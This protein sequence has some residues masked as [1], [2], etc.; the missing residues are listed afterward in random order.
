MIRKL[1]KNENVTQMLRYI[2]LYMN[3]NH[4][5]TFK[6][7]QYCKC[8]VN[9]KSSPFILTIEDETNLLNNHIQKFLK[10]EGV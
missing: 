6:K 8:T 9:V 1:T 7:P 2:F 5:Q 10:Q 4:M 3:T